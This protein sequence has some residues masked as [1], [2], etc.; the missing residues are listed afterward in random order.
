M[1]LP[2]AWQVQPSATETE[3]AASRMQQGSILLVEDDETMRSLVVAYL[4]RE[5]FLV[6]EAST[7]AAALA[8][9]HEPTID[10]IVLDIRL[11]DADGIDLMREIH[12][13]CSVP[14]VIITGN[15]S[16]MDRVLGL[17]LGADD[18]ICK[19]FELRELK[20]RIRSVLRRV[21]GLAET[22]ISDTAEV[23]T[24]A[25]FQLDLTHRRLLDASGAEIE[26]TGGE[27]ELLRVLAEHPRRPLSRDQ[28]LD[29]TRS[30][31]W[32]P[33][34]RSIDVLVGRLRGKLK[35]GGAPPTLITTVRNVGYML[36]TDVKRKRIVGANRDLEQD[37]SSPAA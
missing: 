30:R 35:A 4:R 11:P 25:N 26:L 9:I 14:I 23:L 2:I 15:D 6:E 1:L 8:R 24:F 31:E 18:Y 3:T 16:P 12:Q 19:P 37:R 29:L 33:F 34:D 27:H 17:E 10:L 22:D 5:G 13:S 36:A 28:L 7:G 32:T 21:H 20:A